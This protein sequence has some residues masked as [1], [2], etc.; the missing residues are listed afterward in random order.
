MSLQIK[1]H[2]FSQILTDFYLLIGFI[3]YL[4]DLKGNEA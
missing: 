4:I 1:F 3:D 2:R